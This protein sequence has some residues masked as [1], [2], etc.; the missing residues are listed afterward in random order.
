MY[1]AYC[2][3]NKRNLKRSFFALLYRRIRSFF[4]L[5]STL[6]ALGMTRRQQTPFRVGNDCSMGLL[7][8]FAA[9]SVKCCH[10]WTAVCHIITTQLV[11]S[12]VSDRRLLLRGEEEKLQQNSEITEDDISSSAY[13]ASQLLATRRLKTRTHQMFFKKCL[14]RY[15]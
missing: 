6:P 10:L 2:I 12:I 9:I 13:A 7:R 11:L 3:V 1:R 4:S 14:Y 8:S 15:Q 5:I